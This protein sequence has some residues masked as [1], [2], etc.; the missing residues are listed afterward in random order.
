[1]ELVQSLHTMHL[2]SLDM[3]AHEELERHQG[4]IPDIAISTGHQFHHTGFAAEVGHDS[5]GRVS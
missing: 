3:L 2:Y 1:M 4:L 5:G